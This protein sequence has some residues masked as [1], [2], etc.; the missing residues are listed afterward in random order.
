M[1]KL[2]TQALRT[3]DRNLAERRFLDRKLQAINVRQRMSDNL[4]EKEVKELRNNLR[5]QALLDKENSDEES[6]Y[7]S[8]AGPE[9]D[10]SIV[11]LPSIASQGHVKGSVR[12]QPKGARGGPR[13]SSSSQRGDVTAR[14]KSVPGDLG[15][16]S[17]A[18]PRSSRIHGD[19][20]SWRR[21][22]RKREFPACRYSS[23]TRCRHFP[24][25]TPSTYTAFGFEVDR[26]NASGPRD[27]V[28]TANLV[29]AA[30]RE[31]LIAELENSSVRRPKRSSMDQCVQKQQSLKKI[32]AEMKMK[33]I[34]GRPPD[35]CTNY[36]TPTP[37]RKLFKVARP[38]AGSEDLAGL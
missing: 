25:V 34:A 30:H 37:H 8:E 17:Q 1:Q 23:P 14:S 24:C 15:M 20:V 35:W 9:D 33:S 10:E 11:S 6:E 12:G 28:N 7:E 38:S 5:R 19:T 29:S 32:I 13:L 16:T 18:T 27:I 36:G 2:R 26:V 22:P 3:K 4:I 21:G 31:R